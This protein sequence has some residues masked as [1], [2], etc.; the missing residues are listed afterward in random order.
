MAKTFRLALPD[1]PELAGPEP[2]FQPTIDRS[3]RHDDGQR[4]AISVPSLRSLGIALLQEGLLSSDDLIL[5]LSLHKSEKG[6]LC[7]ILLSREMIGERK[8]YETQA[9]HW[10]LRLIDPTV[11]LADPR[12]IDRL[13]AATCLRE[14]LIP[15]QSFGK[16]TIIATAYPEDFGRHH[17]M[18]TGLF[19][20]VVIAL[21]PKSKIDAAIMAVR[22]SALYKAA[23]NRV[24]AAESCRNWG[25]DRA[26]VKFSF[27]F[28][29]V[30]LGLW[31]S[32]A[33]MALAFTFWAAVTLVLT[34]ALR[35]CAVIAALR[36]K[37]SPFASP[38]IARLPTVSVM[39][40]L[41]KEGEIAPRLIRRLDRLDYPR[42]LLDIVLVVEEEDHLTRSALSGADLPP[43]MRVVVVPDG[44]LKTKPRALNFGLDMCRGSIIGVY[45]AEDA[46]EPDQIRK[47]VNRFYQRDSSVACLQGVLDFYNPETNW[48]SRCFTLEYAAWFRIILPGLQRLGLAIPLGGTTLFFRREALEQLGGWDSHNVTEDADLGMRLARHGYRTELL[49]TT[50]YEEANCRALPWIRQRS[51]WLKGYMMTWAVHMRDP[52]LLWRQLGP[53]KFVGF[54]VL[55]LCTLSQYMLAPVL[56]SFWLLP[57]G[58]PHPLAAALPAVAMVGLIALYLMTEA[59]NIAVNIM[60]LRQ[61]RHNLSWIWALSLHLYFPLGAL[62]SY[63]AAVEMVTKPFYW[64]KT[65]HGHFDQSA[66]D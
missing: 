35:A 37:P 49:D 40:A 29:C 66:M 39:V 50:T 46:P 9:R 28:A 36:Q 62:A 32:P 14:G 56:W 3:P 45:D 44:P 38:A 54:Q 58:V 10:N 57:L 63:K 55:F 13:G 23:E 7:D 2:V 30:A 31:L 5:A 33:I 15:W 27:F 51:R 21:A 61:T 41:F 22:A 26:F 47:V 19:G 4:I 52:R 20:P 43:W 17:K 12:L 64:D 60:G 42:E 48:L 16:V 65:S 24:P 18:L 59:I 6:K 53:R 34:T 11:Q 8:L 1:Q 25:R